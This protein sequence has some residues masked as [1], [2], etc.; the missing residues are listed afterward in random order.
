MRGKRTD[1][2][3]RKFDIAVKLCIYESSVVFR[4]E[5]LQFR[6]LTYERGRLIFAETISN[7]RLQGFLR[8]LSENRGYQLNDTVYCSHPR[9]YLLQ[10]L[11]LN[12][13]LQGY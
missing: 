8:Q 1:E 7:L 10:S 9:A 3:I 11:A 2:Y 6:G 4:T 12:K 13:F 5:N